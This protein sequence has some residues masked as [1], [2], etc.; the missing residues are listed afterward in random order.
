MHWATTRAPADEALTILAIDHRGLF[1]TL[2]DSGGGDEDRVATFKDLASQA[3]ERTAAGDRACGLL[4]DGRFGARALAQSA[5]APYWIGRPI[6]ISGSRPLRFEGGADV[7][8][9]L[10]SWPRPHAVKCNLR[11]HPDDPADLRAEQDAQLLR[12][13][14]ATRARAMNCCWKSSPRPMARWRTIPWRGSWAMSMRWGSI[15]TGGSWRRPTIRPPGPP[16]RR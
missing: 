5:D 7:A 11:Y 4:L 14:D 1:E 13:F 10:R 8:I 3:M 2:I 6:E 15:P 16:S 12:L 9:T